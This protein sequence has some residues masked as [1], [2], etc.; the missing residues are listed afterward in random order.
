MLY[1]FSTFISEYVVLS[2]PY[3]NSITVSSSG[4]GVL[5]LDL[6]GTQPGI[7]T[8][9]VVDNGLKT[10]LLAIHVFLADLFTTVATYEVVRV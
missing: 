5:L 3:M 2:S 1:V 8:P 10:A 9:L 6:T 7:V 4:M